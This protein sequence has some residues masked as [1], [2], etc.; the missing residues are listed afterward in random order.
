M[1]SLFTNGGINND[2]I[3]HDAYNGISHGLVFA[4]YQFEHIY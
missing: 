3:R 1:K 2:V 4:L